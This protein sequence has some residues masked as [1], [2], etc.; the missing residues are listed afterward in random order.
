M[1]VANTNIGALVVATDDK[2]D[3][4]PAA[5]QMGAARLKQNIGEESWIG[6]IVTWP[7]A[8]TVSSVLT[9]HARD[10]GVEHVGAY[11]VVR[12]RPEVLAYEHCK[13]PFEIAHR[14]PPSLGK[15]V[16]LSVG[17]QSAPH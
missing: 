16:D 3:V 1:R 15:P 8:A 2:E 14:A 5:T 12:L 11:S 4:T 6:A 10:A 17:A 9:C 13:A 7:T